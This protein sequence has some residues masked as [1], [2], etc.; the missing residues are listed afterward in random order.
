MKYQD[1][2]NKKL[3]AIWRQI[4]TT[5]ESFDEH[6]LFACA[7]EVHEAYGNPPADVVEVQ[8]SDMQTFVTAVRATGGNNM[9]RNLVVAAYRTDIKLVV[10]SFKA[11]T[12][13]VKNRLLCEVHYYDSWDFCGENGQAYLWGS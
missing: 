1:A 12:D 7:N 5:L 9:N 8:Q 13:T 3:A 10:K 2:N 6:V 11:P 4:A